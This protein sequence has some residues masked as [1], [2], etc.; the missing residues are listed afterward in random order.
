MSDDLAANRRFLMT[1]EQSIRLANKEIIHKV[2]PPV[3]TERM[4]SFAVSVAKLRAQYIEAAFNFA[5]NNTGEA[6]QN[7]DAIEELS[8]YRKQFEETRDAYTALQR[9]VEVGYV[10]I[11]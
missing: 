6:Q 7:S 10:S 11:E 5:D 3:T 2:I 4:L 8:T 9:A 1:A